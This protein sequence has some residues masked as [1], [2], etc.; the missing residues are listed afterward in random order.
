MNSHE[1]SFSAPCETRRYY[2]FQVTNK[3]LKPG[4]INTTT[5]K[6]LLVNLSLHAQLER[7]CICFNRL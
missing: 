5:S 4:R 7:L 3:K 2:Y 6:C 1:F